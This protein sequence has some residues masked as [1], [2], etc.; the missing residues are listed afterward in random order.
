MY[1]SVLPT[2][3]GVTAATV[4][5][6]NEA[7][8]A[9]AIGVLPVSS[10]VNVARILYEPDVTKEQYHGSNGH[11]VLPPHCFVPARVPDVP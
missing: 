6:L 3:G 10:C 4:V 8:S 1:V 9:V 2:T 11:T 7:V 5:M